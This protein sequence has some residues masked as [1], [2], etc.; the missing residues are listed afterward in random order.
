MKTDNPRALT[1]CKTTGQDVYEQG[2][3]DFIAGLEY[4][5]NPYRPGHGKGFDTCWNNGWDDADATNS[6]SRHGWRPEPREV[7]ADEHPTDDLGRPCAWNHV[8]HAHRLD[9]KDIKGDE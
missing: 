2:R 7:M 9:A 4:N 3:A 8:P 5:A 1:D 6:V